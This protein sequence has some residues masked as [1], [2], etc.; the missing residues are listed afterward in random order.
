MNRRDFL[1]HS[2]AT[3]AGFLVLGHPESLHGI[4]T[5]TAHGP[6]ASEPRDLAMRALE[7][8]R[9]AGADWADVRINTNRAQGLSTRDRR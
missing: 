7:T 3:A 9:M 1:Q 6:I 5:P 8:A 4:L 2:A